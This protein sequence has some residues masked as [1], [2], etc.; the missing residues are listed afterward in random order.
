[1]N[2]NVGKAKYIFLVIAFLLPLVIPAPVQA[3]AIEADFTAT[4]LEGPPGTEVGFTN[5]T[6]GE[7]EAYHWDFGDGEES[8]EENPTHV[9]DSVGSYTVTL[10][11]SG[12]AG[13]DVATK[14]DYITIAWEEVAANF[15]GDNL[16]GDP[17]LD[18]HFTD[19]STGDPNSWDWDFGDGGEG[20]GEQNPNHVY[21][22]PGSFTVSLTAQNPTY[23]DT[24]EKVGYVNIPPQ[25]DFTGSPLL[26]V[27]TLVVSFTDQTVG[28][29]DTYA[30]DFGDGGTSTAANPGHTYSNPGIFTVSL[31]VTGEGGSKTETKKSYVIVEDDAPV[32]ADFSADITSGDPPLEVAFTDLSTGIPTSWSWDFGDGDTSNE[33]NPTHTYQDPGTYEVELTVTDS[34]SD[35]TETKVGYVNIPPQP[36]FTADVTSGDTPLEVNFTDQTV[37]TVTTYAWDFGDGGVSSLQNPTHTYTTPGLYTVSLEVEGPGGEKTETKTGYVSIP[38]QPDFTS[39]VTFGYAPLE[40]NFTDQTAGTVTAY[41]WSFG[42]TGTSTLQNPTHTYTTPG[43]YTVSLEVTGPGG[44]KTET[45]VGYVVAAG[46]MADFDGDDMS[47]PAKFYSGTGTVWWLAS[48]TGS[49]DGLWLGGDTFEYVTGDFDGD[50]KNDPAKFYSS[51]G[52]VWWV[53]SSTGA[54]DGQWLGADA[55]A[56]V[57]DSDFDGDG[58]SDPTKFYSGTGTV[59]WVESSTGNLNGM[60]LGGDT[61]TYVPGSDFDGDGKTDPAKFY[62]GTGVVWWVASSTGTMDGMW[63][64]GDTFTY[65][66]GSDF[67]GDGKSD[68]A[69]FY[70]N[71]GVVWWVESSTGSMEGAWLGPAGTFTFVGGNDF[72]GDNKTDPAKFE[73]STGTLSWIKSSTGE[74]DSANLGTGLYEVVN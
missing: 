33:R 15:I 70:E 46:P 60:W 30:W 34:E 63:L 51:T 23:S 42:D 57:S 20:S 40:V 45:K 26:G 22:E 59:W 65:V 8:T 66:P 62:Q 67:D 9:Y 52:T 50:G 72:D 64:G 19:T 47:D 73:A 24:E 58:K 14:V 36:E 13:D 53:A 17:P 4:P 27:N 61:F 11:A 71:T 43:A 48:S 3:D 18:V 7:V 25:P 41:A 49:W 21:T 6:S 1:M 2:K 37:G 32:S 56:Y 12:S 39:N 10:T 5:E 54:M 55:F 28:T 35:D 16:S 31:T 29:V 68:P 69:K 74:W 38:P 44:T